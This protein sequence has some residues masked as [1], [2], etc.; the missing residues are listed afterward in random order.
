MT[1]LSVIDTA[2]P[3]MITDS[4]GSDIWTFVQSATKASHINTLKESLW[5]IVVTVQL[6]VVLIN[7]VKFP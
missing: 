6:A 7:L 4:N 1:D 3:T 5:I 2:F